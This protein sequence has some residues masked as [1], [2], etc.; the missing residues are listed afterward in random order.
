M[1]VKQIQAEETH[2][3]RHKVLWPHL[4]AEDDCVIDID[5]R[6]DAIHLAVVDGEKIITIASFFAMHSPRL[7]NRNQ[8][9]LRAMAT[10]PDYRKKNAGRLL[11]EKAM[12][13]LRDKG[14]EVLWCDARLGALGFYQSLGFDMMEDVYEIPRI[15]PHRFMF[16]MLQA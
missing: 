7:S 8:V 2:H 12:E 3:L 5:K 11:L 9:R 10:D 1:E 14:Y 6:E 4:N 16:R 13:I 15:G